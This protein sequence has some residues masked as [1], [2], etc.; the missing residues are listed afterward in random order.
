MEPT[1]MTGRHILE[2]NA[3][4][5][6]QS[7]QR[8]DIITFRSEDGDTYCKRIIGMPGDE[9]EFH[10]GYVYINSEQL[11]ESSYLD[12]DIETNCIGTF[13]VPE[14]CYFVMG[15]NREN[16]SDSRFWLMPT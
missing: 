16:S 14:D 12:D 7:P 3:A 4:Y 5:L 2:C 10:N 9:I 15:D 11:D 8:G 13:L 1:L 6:I